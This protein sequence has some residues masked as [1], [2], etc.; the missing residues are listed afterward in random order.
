M[1]LFDFN[2]QFVGYAAYH[3]NK[4]NQWIHF[5]CVPMILWTALVWLQNTP[6]FFTWSLSKELPINM[7]FVLTVIYSGYYV[8]L[9]TVIGGMLAPVMVL[10]FYTSNVF[11]HS[12]TEVESTLT[13]LPAGIHIVSWIAQFLGHGLAEKRRPALMDNLLHGKMIRLR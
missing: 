2:R 6:E 8:M 13:S 3:N 11:L 7:A 10:A 9:H 12:K 1:S 4:V 5:V